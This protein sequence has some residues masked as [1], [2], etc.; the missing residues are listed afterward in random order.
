VKR[1]FTLLTRPGCHLCEDFE[2]E[3]AALLAGRAEIE[4]ALVDHHP[5]WRQAYGDRIPVLLD[6]AGQFICA[7]TVD[8]NAL[9]AVLV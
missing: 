7:V 4:C 3:V 8:E 1:H 6:D 9:T 5:E 2:S